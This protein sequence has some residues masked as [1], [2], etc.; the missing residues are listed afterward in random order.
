MSAR[1]DHGGAAVA[2]GPG[3]GHDAKP[4]AA[5]GAEDG[6][7][8]GRAQA[9]ED[10]SGG[11]GRKSDEE[12]LVSASGEVG[13]NRLPAER[14]RRQG[15]ESAV[16]HA[17]PV[18]ESGGPDGCPGLAARGGV[19]VDGEDRPAAE[20]GPGQAEEPRAAARVEGRSWG[21]DAKRGEGRRRRRVVARPEGRPRSLNELEP[22]VGGGEMARTSTVEAGDEGAR[23]IRPAGSESE[24]ARGEGQAGEG[25]GGPLG[26]RPRCAGHAVRPE[27]DGLQVADR[28][29]DPCK[30]GRLRLD[31]KAGREGLRGG[32]WLH[33]GRG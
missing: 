1:A 3:H 10:G 30:A 26:R 6:R 19:G 4:Q 13:E 17:D 21:E 22:A 11:R 23:G 5:V 32:R 7:K 8:L 27:R 25:R 2:A 24:R 16:L 29:E 9:C 28:A 14:L 15:L 31:E 33:R 12:G 20:A 18:G